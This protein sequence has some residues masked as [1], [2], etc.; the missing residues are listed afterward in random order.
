MIGRFSLKRST[1]GFTLIE[2]LVVVVMI[3]ILAA[4]AGPS[5]VAFM[6]S[7]RAGGAADQIMQAL[8]QAQAEAIRARRN[9]TVVF[10]V[11]IDPPSIT[12]VG[13]TTTLGQG[14]QLG[15]NSFRPGMVSMQV[16]DGSASDTDCPDTNCIEFDDRGT[17]RNPTGETGI[18]IVVSAPATGGA[19]R[20]VI[21]QTKLGAMRKESDTDCP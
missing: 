9:E 14:L 19:K 20:C 17:V 21:V 16:L 13:V 15:E 6:N 4:I 1:A 5:W 10:N 8:R 7:R 18:K 2:M 12:S 11:N 3:G